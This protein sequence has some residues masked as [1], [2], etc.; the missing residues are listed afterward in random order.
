MT[1]L[2]KVAWLVGMLLVAGCTAGSAGPVRSEPAATMLDGGSGA[3]ALGTAP[4]ESA[5]SMPVS[6]STPQSAPTPATSA[7]T[8]RP[9]PAHDTFTAGQIAVVVATDGV[10]MRTKPSAGSDSGRFAPLL[11]MGTDVYVIGGPSQ[12]SGYQWYQISPITWHPTGLLGSPEVH[13]DPGSVGWVAGAGRDG[14]A[15]LAH[16]T[17]DCPERPADVSALAST[18]VGARLACFGRVPITVRAMIADCGCSVTGPCDVY[19]P[20]WFNVTVSGGYFA[21]YPPGAH[22][23]ESL[24]DRRDEVPLFLAPTA[25]GAEPL[26]LG[27][28]V[29]VTGVFD[30]PAA[31]SCKQDLAAGTGAT[32]NWVAS[33]YC[34]RVFVVTGLK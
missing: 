32:P 15:W 34:R 4:P 28:I 11:P 30:H 1:R 14:E 12:G 18:T 19:R 31:A 26:P 27:R 8:S 13:P 17:A 2:T 20:E 7:P 25:T 5:A 23:A 29:T 33:D 24:E 10:R 22:P 9:T 16:G 6:I 21:L 3:G